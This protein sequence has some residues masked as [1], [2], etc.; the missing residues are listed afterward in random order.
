MHLCVCSFWSVATLLS[1]LAYPLQATLQPRLLANNPISREFVVGG[2]QVIFTPGTRTVNDEGSRQH[3]RHGESMTLFAVIPTRNLIVD[4][5][6]SHSILSDGSDLDGLSRESS[7]Q[8]SALQTPLDSPGGPRERIKQI[9]VEA[10]TR[11]GEFARLLE[12]H[13]QV[14]RKLK[15]MEAEEQLSTTTT[16]TTGN[17]AVIGGAHA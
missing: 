11:R 7:S 3:R 5:V 9:Q 2:Y 14:V 10:E 17:T 15:M 8:N 12:E 16:T 4:D 6:D 1:E 13:A